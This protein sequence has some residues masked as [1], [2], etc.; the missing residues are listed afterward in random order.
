[1]FS[2]TKLKILKFF[3]RIKLQLQVIF[4]E[5]GKPTREGVV[6]VLKENALTI[7]TIMG[8]MGGVIL[9]ISL[10]ASR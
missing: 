2:N 10:R 7:F 9:G 1:V 5:M 4:A 8:V 3:G 6:K